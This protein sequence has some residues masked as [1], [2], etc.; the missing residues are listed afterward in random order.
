MIISGVS[1]VTTYNQ[2]CL[3]EITGSRYLEQQ[4]ITALSPR[5]PQTDCMYGCISNNTRNK[6]INITVKQLRDNMATTFEKKLSTP[7][8]ESY[9][10]IR[11][12]RQRG[13]IYSLYRVQI[14]STKIARLHAPQTCSQIGR[15]LN[16][17]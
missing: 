14:P 1:G 16:F 7:V 8:C 15:S 4:N 6:S 10:G 17:S 2:V 9:V 12:W 3:Y 11:Y 13:A 5:N